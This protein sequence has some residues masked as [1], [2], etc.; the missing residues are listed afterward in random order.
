[1][2][3]DEVF[4]SNSDTSKNLREW[5]TLPDDQVRHI[6]APDGAPTGEGEISVPPSYYAENGT[7]VDP[8]TDKDMSYVRTEIR[9]VYHV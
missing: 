5:S 6:W 8:E 2:M 7:P 3:V 9:G 1:M 4:L